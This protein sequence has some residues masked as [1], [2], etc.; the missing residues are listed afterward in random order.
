MR[1]GQG[2]EAFFA[3]QGI[4]IVGASDDITKIGGR[5]VHLLKKYGYGGPIYPVNPRGGTVQ[6]LTAYASVRDLPTAPDMAVLAVPAAA[7]ANALR[8][9]A[10]RGVKAAVVL[11]SGFA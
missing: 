4:A 5:P 3:A 1:P 11:T 10:A 7:T 9:C 8:D 6:G 2:M